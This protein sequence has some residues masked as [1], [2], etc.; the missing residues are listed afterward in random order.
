[1]HRGL[2]NLPEVAQLETELGLTPGG[3]ALDSRAT[4]GIRVF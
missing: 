4:E 2:S 1:M 3:L